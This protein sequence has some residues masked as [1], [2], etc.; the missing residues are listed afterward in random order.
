MSIDRKLINIQTP[1]PQQGFLGAGHIARPVIQTVYSTS[2]PFIMLMDDRLDKQDGE[3]VGGPHPHAGFETVCSVLEGQIGDA[4]KMMKEG[5]LQIMTAGSG[6]VHAETIQTETQMHLLQ[7]WLNLPQK[8]RWTL[9]RVQDLTLEKVPKVSGNG[10]D[11]LVYSGSFAGLFS[12]IQNYV[13]LTIADIRMQPGITTTQQLPASYTAFLYVIA[14]S[15]EAG[16]DSKSLGQNQVGWLD[17]YPGKDQSELK[18]SAGA[19]G[20]RI[21]LYAAQPQ[22]EPFVPYGPFI[23]DTQ[24]DIARLYKDYRQGKMKHI[25]TVPEAQ[26]ILY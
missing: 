25:S 14:G 8:D 16:E 1:T 2:D 13:P 3:P 18:L 10:F 20:A 26:R 21:I 9:P 6:I 11:I 19:S 5:D 12:P 15:V 4:P 22:G 24:K 23:A 17:K 7:L